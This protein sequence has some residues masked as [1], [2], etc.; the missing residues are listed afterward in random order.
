[1]V[2]VARTTI[3]GSSDRT[4]TLAG[5]AAGTEYTVAVTTASGDQHSNTV[6]LSFFTSKYLG[7]SLLQRYNK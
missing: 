6:R 3:N 4:A 1:M 7:K 5:L 2:H